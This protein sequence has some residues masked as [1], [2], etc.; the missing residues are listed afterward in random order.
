MQRVH[1]GS[2]G[3]DKLVVGSKRL[4]RGLVAELVVQVVQHR[5]RGAQI[6]C[7]GAMERERQHRAVLLQH[8]ARAVEHAQFVAIDVELD[9]V[10]ARQ[11]HLDRDVIEAP[12]FDELRVFAVAQRRGV[13]RCDAWSLAVDV[14]QRDRNN[15]DSAL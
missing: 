14:R 1:V 11:S 4:A 6:R 5:E 13:L 12:H 10:D 2:A 9:E 8:V 15:R 7:R 3:C